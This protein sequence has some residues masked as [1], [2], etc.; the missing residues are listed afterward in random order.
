[1][2]AAGEPGRAL[3]SAVVRQAAEGAAG[4]GGLGAA[5][6]GELG[7][8]VLCAVEATTTMTMAAAAA[9]MMTMASVQASCHHAGLGPTRVGR[10]EAMLSEE[11][12]G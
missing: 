10:A 12:T 6:V 3:G 8:A 4:L 11:R 5:V 9:A 7:A 2:P 1:M